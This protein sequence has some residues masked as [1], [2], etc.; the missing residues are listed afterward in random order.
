MCLVSL[1]ILNIGLFIDQNSMD[2]QVIFYLRALSKT[3]LISLMYT[4]RLSILLLFK[5]EF[6]NQVPS[7]EKEAS[8]ISLSTFSWLTPLI[9]LGNTKPLEDADLWDLSN[10]GSLL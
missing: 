5:Q 6:G 8:F 1:S 10:Q 7:P 2:N 9:D 3:L 4:E